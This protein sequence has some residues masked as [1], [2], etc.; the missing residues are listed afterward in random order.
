MQS[1]I[2][3]YVLSAK[4]RFLLKRVVKLISLSLERVSHGSS[5]IH[6]KAYK[7]LVCE[8]GGFQNVLRDA[9]VCA[10]PT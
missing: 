2:T 4:W 1:F 9:C 7:C 10:V 8:F 6:E 3:R 5:K